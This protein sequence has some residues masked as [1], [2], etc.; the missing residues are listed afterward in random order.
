V[1]LGCNDFEVIDLGVMVPCDQILAE[2]R[3]HG[4]DMIGLSGLIT[5]SLDE[6]V[7]VAR[8][9]QR[10]GFEMPL[11]IGGATTSAKHTAVKIAPAY[12][13]PVVHV[14]DASRSVPVVEKLTR[15]ETREQLD[16]DNRAFQQKERDAFAKRR[17]RKLVPYAEAVKRR[18]VIDWP[19]T[20]IA[21][22]SFLGLKVMR[23]FPLGEIVPYI[24]W[25]PFFMTWEM[26]GKYPQI[27]KDPH[28]GAEA[29]KLFDHANRLLKRVVDEKL[30][31]AHAVH[32]FFPANADGDDVVIW[33]DES[34]TTERLRL[35][36]L[37]QQWEREGQTSFRSLA[38]YV[39]PKESGRAD[40]L[41]A[42]AVTAG[43]GMAELVAGF[44]AKGDDYNA[45]MAEALA[46]RLAEALAELL[47]E[48]VRV[49]WGYGRG[50][51]L[52]KDDL[53][54][55]KYR[56]IRPAAGYPSCPDHTEKAKLWS[57]LDVESATG[58][59]LTESFA[60][61]PA[62]SVS[63]LYFAHPEA[64]YFAVDLV[65]RDQVESYAARKGMP[66]AEV[67]KWLSPN[68]AYEAEG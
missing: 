28:A 10:E 13:G 48:R 55:E 66:R 52:S 19:T 53:I 57:M 20:E 61:L 1:V 29:T 38:D 68:L 9:M 64:S 44:K 67:E 17:E 31:A 3:K 35:P 8:E 6:M 4:V 41:G 47:H 24:D 56:G 12:H 32:G 22:P 21:V 23:A 59:R 30:L 37:R 42:F 43:A 46:D 58:I 5:P 54:A 15:P 40:Y 27:L 51:R 60:M 26:P 62:A 65:T 39:A 16:R 11:L 18:F 25:S 14:K 34:R 7:H 33:T 45:I 50:E 36:M 63:G 49:E 2:A